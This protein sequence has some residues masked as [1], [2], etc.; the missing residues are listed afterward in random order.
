MSSTSINREFTRATAT[1]ASGQSLSGAVSI[2]GSVLAAL[3]IPAAWTAA[4]LSFQSSIDGGTTWADVFDDGGAEV[5]I[6][7]ASIPTAAARAI[8]NGT[9]L[10]KLAGLTMI[11]CRSGLSGAAVNQGADRAL[12]FIFKT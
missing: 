3:H 7:S 2:G 4:A 11:R 10:E 1:I 6:P 8:V 9:I 12:T 5:A